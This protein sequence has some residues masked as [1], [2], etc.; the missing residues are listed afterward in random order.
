MPVGDLHVVSAGRRAPVDEEHTYLF[1]D[2][3]MVGVSCLRGAGR[4][5]KL[6]HPIAEHGMFHVGKRFSSWRDNQEALQVDA[7]C[8]ASLL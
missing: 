7:I 3:Q 2:D 8:C 1:L 5:L 4:A 6:C